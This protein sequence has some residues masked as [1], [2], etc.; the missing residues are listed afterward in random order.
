[1]DRQ[2]TERVLSTKNI[3]D[4]LEKLKTTFEDIELKFEGGESSQEAMK[5]IVEV[6]E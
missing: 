1:M 3:S 5:R 6:V 4:W 2:L